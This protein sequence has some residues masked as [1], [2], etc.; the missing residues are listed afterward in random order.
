MY[1]APMNTLPAIL[2]RLRTSKL[3]LQER[4][5]IERMGVFGS[6]AR[7]DARDGSDIDIVVEFNEPIG[8]EFVDLADELEALLNNKVDLVSKN[9]IRSRYWAHIEPDVVYV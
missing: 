3:R 1:I 8:I 7:G 6:I 2:E 5:P 4:Y 9:A